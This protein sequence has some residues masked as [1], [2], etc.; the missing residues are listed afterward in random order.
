[1]EFWIMGGCI[2][3]MNGKGCTGMR[4]YFLVL[5]LVGVLICGWG[6]GQQTVDVRFAWDANVPED[7]VTEYCLYHSLTSGSGYAL[8]SCVDG[9]TLENTHLIPVDGAVN[10]WVVTAKNLIRESGYSNEVSLKAAAPGPV[11]LRIDGVNPGSG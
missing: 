3:F 1:M 7:N 6:F 9:A 11:N 5:F 8:V 4:R 10:Y 2:L